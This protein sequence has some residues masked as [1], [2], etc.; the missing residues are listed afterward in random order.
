MELFTIAGPESVDGLK[1]TPEYALMTSSADLLRKQ[2][3]VAALPDRSLQPSFFA[4][5]SQ[6]AVLTFP[7]MNLGVEGFRMKA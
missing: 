4:P 5:S 1:L 6:P 2:S 3:K 7:G